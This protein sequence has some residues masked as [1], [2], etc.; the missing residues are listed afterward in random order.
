[1]ALLSAL[2]RGLIDGLRL[3]RLWCWPRLRETSSE[4][5]RTGFSEVCLCE[6]AYN[7]FGNWVQMRTELHE[8]SRQNIPLERRHYQIGLWESK[9]QIFCPV[10]IRSKHSRFVRHLALVL[11]Y[12]VAEV[13]NPNQQVLFAVVVIILL[14]I[15]SLQLIKKASLNVPLC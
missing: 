2:K 15:F 14:I 12:V 13:N 5:A 10:N 3:K 8:D 6:K 1:M 9:N 7:R 4:P 11:S